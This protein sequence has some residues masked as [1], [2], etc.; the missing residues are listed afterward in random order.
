[1]LSGLLALLWAAHAY[2]WPDGGFWAC[3]TFFTFP[4]PVSLCPL[5]FS[6]TRSTLSF[7][8]FCHTRL[9]PSP[10]P[11]PDPAA[12]AFEVVIIRE[13]THRLLIR[14]LILSVLLHGR[15]PFV[16]CGD[17]ACGHHRELCGA[18]P[19]VDAAVPCCTDRSPVASAGLAR[20]LLLMCRTG[21]G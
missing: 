10:P 15:S 13:R 20:R 12:L 7:T 9:F 21:P 17:C 3:Q 16:S 1:M 11:P 2:P 6:A 5:P 18:M 19:R 14:P 8:F 4:R